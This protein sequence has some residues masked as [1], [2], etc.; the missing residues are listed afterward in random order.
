MEWLVKLIFFL[1]LAPFLFSLAVQ[2]LSALV[3]G[4]LWL[5]G[6]AILMG[7]VAGISA[8]LVLR[9]RLPRRYREYPPPGVPPVRR[10]REVRGRDED[11]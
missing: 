8:G 2:V 11:E 5:I 7:L 10:P 4:F 9:R 3:T 6:L 1:I